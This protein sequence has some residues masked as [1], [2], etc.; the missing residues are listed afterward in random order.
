MQLQLT[1]S[2]LSGDSRCLELQV[3]TNLPHIERTSPDLAKSGG[4]AP[5]LVLRYK[6]QCL[7]NSP[8]S[9]DLANKISINSLPC[10]PASSAVSEDFPITGFHKNGDTSNPTSIALAPRFAG[11]NYPGLN[12]IGFALAK[13]NYANGGLVPPHTHPRAAEVIYV[14]KG[15]VHVGFVDTVGKLFATT[16]NKSDCLFVCLF[17]LFSVEL[18]HFQLNVGSGHAVT[19]LVLNG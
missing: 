7:Q 15:E 18:V 1:G 13:F 2:F 5:Y 8:N 3:S 14:V 16:L 11:I 17:F 6:Q 4:I 12:S 10:K 19:I 9:D